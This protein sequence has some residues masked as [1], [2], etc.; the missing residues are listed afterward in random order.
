MVTMYR[1]V[2]K[3]AQMDIK[4][5]KVVLVS[6][7]LYSLQFQISKSHMKGSTLCTQTTFC[8]LAKLEQK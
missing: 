7:E 6:S 1:G 8:T 4:G 5:A 3:L 2:L